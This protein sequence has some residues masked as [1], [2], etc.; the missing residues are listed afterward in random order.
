[1]SGGAGAC[2]SIAGQIGKIKGCRVIG[3][4]G[5]DEKIAYMKSIGFDE[6]VNYKGKT[7]DQLYEEIKRLCPNGV[8]IYYD[9][10]GGDISVSV[11]R[12]M[13]NNG[14]VP[15][16]GQISQY[17]KLEMDPLPKEIEDELKVKNVDRRWF[18]VFSYKD[19]F[20]GGWS[21]MLTWVNNGSLKLHQT[22]YDGIEKMPDA[23]F[24]LFTGDNVGKLSVK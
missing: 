4:A 15:I 24:A 19:Q 16:C 13:N 21:E 2:G 14:R 11:L 18:M 6:G 17:N 5:S 20:E 9:N 23:F 10:V 7:K 22:L 1:V 12:L 8:D 3:I